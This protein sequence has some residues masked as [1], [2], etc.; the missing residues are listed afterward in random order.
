MEIGNQARPSLFDLSIVKPA[1]LYH[2]VTEVEERLDADGNIIRKLDEQKLELDLTNLYNSGLQ[3]V[4]I[5]L[6][7]SWKNS[8]H[9]ERCYDIAKKVGF[10]NISILSR[11]MPLIKIVGRSDN[12]C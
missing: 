9:E 4:A 7:H 6:M 1:Q 12:G 3:S 2:S 8:V 10:S 11:I 5:V